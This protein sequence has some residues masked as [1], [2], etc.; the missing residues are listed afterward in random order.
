[1]SSR[2]AQFIARAAAAGGQPLKGICQSVRGNLDRLDAD[3]YI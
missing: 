1:M 3:A 2:Q